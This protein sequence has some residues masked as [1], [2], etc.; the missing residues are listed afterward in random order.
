M[1]A[2]RAFNEGTEAMR[3]PEEIKHAYAELSNKPEPMREMGDT[4]QFGFLQGKVL[5][6]GWALEEAGG[7]SL[8]MDLDYEDWKREYD[9]ET[10]ALREALNKL[11][12][13]PNDDESQPNQERQHNDDRQSRV[14]DLD[15][16]P[17]MDAGRAFSKESE[18][19]KWTMG[20]QS[21]GHPCVL[22]R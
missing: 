12:D 6:L 10:K 1:D 20:K 16:W 9:A 19:T 17:G 21:A 22:W 3:D 11:S 7:G 8:A 14:N 2:G 13:R 4:F 18:A 15:A 5:A